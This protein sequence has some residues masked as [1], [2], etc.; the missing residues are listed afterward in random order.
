MAAPLRIGSPAAAP[1]GVVPEN[2][3]APV[4]EPVKDY[5]GR[6]VKLIPSE[7]IGLYL[8]GVGIIP[9][10]QKP[11]FAIWAA[12]CFLLVILVRAYATSDQ[13]S[14]LKPQWIAVAISAISFVIW[15]YTLGG[16]FADYGLYQPYIGSLAVLVWIFVVPFFYKGEE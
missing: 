7:V 11:A 3:V 12:V 15:V 2:A 10:D 16:P 4:A 8:L 13:A 6:L 5:I 9:A 14:G 1:P